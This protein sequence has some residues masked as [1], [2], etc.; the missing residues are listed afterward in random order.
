L[1]QRKK[2]G[3]MKNISCPLQIA[4]NSAPDFVVI[5]QE[6]RHRDKMREV[7]KE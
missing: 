4:C 3:G 6:K 2:R 5:Y 1:L 7:R